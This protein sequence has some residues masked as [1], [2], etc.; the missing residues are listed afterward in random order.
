MQNQTNIEKLNTKVLDMIERYNSLKNE[1]ETMRTELITLKAEKEINFIK[2]KIDALV[3]DVTLWET[4]MSFFSKSKN[5][6]LLKADF[7][8]KIEK[9]KGDIKYFKAKLR[10]FDKMK[11]SL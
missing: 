8:K 11:R 1:T 10:Q 2:G 3:K 9:A 6:D 7:Q 5:A 4:N